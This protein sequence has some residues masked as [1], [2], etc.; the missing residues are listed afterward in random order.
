MSHCSPLGEVA[1]AAVRV[2]NME[3]TTVL[4][5]LECAFGG[6]HVASNGERYATSLNAKDDLTEGASDNAKLRTCYFRSSTNVVRKI[7]KMEEKGCFLE[8]EARAPGTETMLEPN[9]DEAVVYK[10]FFIAGLRMHP[11]PTLADILLHFQAQLHQLTPNA[12]T[13]LSKFFWAVGSFGGVPSA[14]LFVK[15]YELHYQPKT[16]ETPEGDQIAQYGCL[17]FHAKRDGGLKLSLVIKNKWSATWTKSWFYCHVPCRRCSGGGKCMYA[18]HSWMSELDYAIE[19]E[20]DCPD[21][22]PND[23]AFV[24]ATTTI[25][26]CDA[27]EEYIA[28]KIYPLAASFG[29][30]S[31][32]LGTTPMSK[33]QTP[34]PLFA[35]GTIAVEHAGCFLTEVKKEAER[36]LGSFGPREYDS[37]LVANIM[38]DS[39]LNHIHEQMGVPYFPCPQPGF[40]SSQAAN[41]KRKAKVAKKPAA[42][43]V[44]AGSGQAPSSKMVPPLPKVRPSKKVG[45]LKI[46]QLKAKPG[47][48]CTSEI[49]LAL[50]KPVGVSKKFHLLDLAASSHKPRSVGAATTRIARVSAFDN[51]DDDSSSDVRKT[52]SPGKMIEKHVSPPPS[53]SGEFLRFS[54]TI[55]PTGPDN[56]FLRSNLVCA[57]TRVAARESR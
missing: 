7:K 35:V 44:K 38:Y 31:V 43:K 28:C 50:A 32:P 29:F 15:R 24:R 25:E 27:I 19:P 55:F 39:R 4:A 16:V 49:E 3:E 5:E 52:P 36:V 51:L 41:K 10:D 17:N 42:K 34:L 11:H 14:N 18:L 2:E 6:N 47:P 26:G 54:F 48:R 30:K 57:L 40:T 37:L 46:A 12:I 23:D 21:N 33:V 45:V 20:V 8:D 13:Q 1:A 53:V 9:G 22:V 56:F